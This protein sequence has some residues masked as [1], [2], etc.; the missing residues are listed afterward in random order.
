MSNY[1]QFLGSFL[2]SILMVQVLCAGFHDEHPMYTAAKAASIFTGIILVLECAKRGLPKTKLYDYFSR[3]VA[4]P[5]YEKLNDDDPDPLAEE[6]EEK[7]TP[8]QMRQKVEK[9]FTTM[10]TRYQKRLTI[11]GAVVTVA[12][13]LKNQW[14]EAL[15]SNMRWM[16][17]RTTIF[18]S[19]LYFFGDTHGPLERTFETPWARECVWVAAALGYTALTY[20]ETKEIEINPYAFEDTQEWVIT[21]FSFLF[22]ITSQKNYKQTSKRHKA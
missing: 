7:L 5:T 2:L 3:H 9:S 21:I 16:Q 13:G 12:A 10:M 19:L 8:A 1:K 22:E 6:K 18:I 15:S 20:N 11:I 14:L 4:Y 17:V